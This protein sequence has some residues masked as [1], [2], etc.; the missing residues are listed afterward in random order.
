M[1]DAIERVERR[2]ESEDRPESRRFELASRD[3]VHRSRRG[4]G[5]IRRNPD[6]AQ[7][8]VHREP[9]GADT[10]RLEKRVHPGEVAG[11]GNERG[12]RRRHERETDLARETLNYDEGQGEDE[13]GERQS[14]S[15]SRKRCCARLL[16]EARER[17]GVGSNSQQERD[18]DT[19]HG[20]LHATRKGQ[21]RDGSRGEVKRDG[22]EVGDRN[23]L[24]A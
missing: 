12:D 5:R 21:R 18:D 7:H 19:T 14:W 1:I 23:H 16:G 22:K 24:I 17:G 10:L 20:C 3:E 2:E 8:D 11:H 9:D 15:E 4:R 13:T 6:E